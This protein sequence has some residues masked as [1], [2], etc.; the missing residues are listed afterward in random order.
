MGFSLTTDP[1]EQQEVTKGIPYR[2]S[3]VSI[4]TRQHTAL[5]LGF[6]SAGS[7]AYCCSCNM[8][9]LCIVSGGKHILNNWVMSWVFS[10]IKGFSKYSKKYIIVLIKFYF[11]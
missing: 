5:L 3:I 8:T 10:E 1:Q 6:L 2:T 7:L 9:F 4:R 11:P